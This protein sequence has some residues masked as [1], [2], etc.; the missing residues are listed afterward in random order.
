MKDASKSCVTAVIIILAVMPSLSASAI[1]CQLACK[2]CRNRSEHPSIVTVYCEMCDECRAK[3]DKRLRMGTTLMEAPTYQ[4]VIE[5][6]DLAD[7]PTA[8]QC[9]AEE[10]TTSTTSTTTKKP[11][12]PPPKCVL[13]K[14]PP[15]P[16]PPP[17][18][19]PMSCVPCMPPCPMP[20]PMWPGF[21]FPP[22]PPT[23]SGASAATT[24]AAQ[25]ATT[26]GA[27]STTGSSTNDAAN[28]DYLSVFVGIPKDMQLDG[29]EEDV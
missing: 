21:P 15:P 3:R 29:L 28:S 20:M 13:K 2:K 26:K 16:P 1:G 24:A 25:D 23:A 8:P 12:P 7:C 14:P 11:C 22:S 6:D 19:G 9:S 5:V 17:C 27:A 18:M 10:T 4:E